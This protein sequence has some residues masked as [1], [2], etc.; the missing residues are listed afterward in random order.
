M[1]EAEEE[2]EEE[3]EEDAEEDAE[4]S[5]TEAAEIEE[6]EE[7]ENE[8]EADAAEDEEELIEIDDYETPLGLGLIQIS[9]TVSG[10]TV[11][12]SY[13]ENSGIPAD[14]E[15]VVSKITSGAEYEE[16]LEL[17]R[18]SL[19]EGKALDDFFLLDV[20]IQADGEDYT[21]NGNY[22]VSVF[23]S[24]AADDHVKLIQF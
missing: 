24:D 4:E 8:E 20:T 1:E 21:D 23:S 12:V 18:A 14:A 10:T 11:V 5:E 13:Y 2:T 19:D 17:A 15:L 22:D 16:Y 7:V 3:A 6:A 9:A